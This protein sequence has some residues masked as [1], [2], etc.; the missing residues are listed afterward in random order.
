MPRK[1]L[2][3][4]NGGDVET[5]NHLSVTIEELQ[6]EESENVLSIGDDTDTDKLI[7]FYKGA[8]G[9]KTLSNSNYPIEWATPIFVPKNSD[10]GESVNSVIIEKRLAP[11]LA[12][13]AVGDS[14][15]EALPRIAERAGSEEPIDYNMISWGVDRLEKLAA[16]YVETIEAEQLLAYFEN[17][18]EIC[19]NIHLEGSNPIAKIIKE[20]TEKSVFD[21]R[22]QNFD[23]SLNAKKVPTTIRLSPDLYWH[24]K[25]LFTLTY[26]TDCTAILEA[27][28]RG[29]QIEYEQLTEL[30]DTVDIAMKHEQYAFIKTFVSC[31]RYLWRVDD[32]YKQAKFDAPAISPVTGRKTIEVESRLKANPFDTKIDMSQE[33]VIDLSGE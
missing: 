11:K 12:D 9:N 21:H 24:L 10:K 32:D 33:L 30:S 8:L 7:E 29:E 19:D 23:I 28:K 14:T 1:K 22:S 17:A 3:P 26:T 4:N 27:V 20:I 6:D 31:A 5:L 16:Q 13:W 25:L 18:L 2:I 15:S